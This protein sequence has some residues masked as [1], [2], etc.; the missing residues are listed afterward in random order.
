MD[1][2][3][4]LTSAT[5]FKRVRREGKSYA[6]PLVILV[7]NPN[8]LNAPRFGF[9]AGKAVGN[10]VR[11]NRAKRRLREALRGYLPFM[12]GGW[13]VVLIARPK[14]IDADWSELR[15][16]IEHLLRQAGLLS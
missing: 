4:R 9:T 3:Y 12:L 11:R 7:A 5:D 15:T 1:R 8:G 14:L 6:H 13:D 2:E 10:A 16:A